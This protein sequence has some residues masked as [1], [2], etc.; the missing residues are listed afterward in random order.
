MLGST[1]DAII[2]QQ[3]SPSG[4]EAPATE[5]VMLGP[6]AGIVGGAFFLAAS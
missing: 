6:Q 4:V 1:F 2:A 5:T 3:F